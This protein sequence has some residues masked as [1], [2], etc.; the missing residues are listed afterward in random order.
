LKGQLLQCGLGL[1]LNHNNKYN[2]SRQ[3]RIRGKL[4][5]GNFAL[6]PIGTAYW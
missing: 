6:S 1:G 3:M 4:T 2:L 5:V